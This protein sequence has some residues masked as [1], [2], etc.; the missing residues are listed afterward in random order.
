MALIAF[1][2][3]LEVGLLRRCDEAESL[4]ALMEIMVWTPHGSW[5]SC[6]HLGLRDF[7]EQDA[8]I[9]VRAL[10][11]QRVQEL[12]HALEELGVVCYRLRSLIRE[13]EADRDV[14]SYVLTFESA[15]GDRGTSIHLQRTK[16]DVMPYVIR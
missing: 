3:Q 6:K 13:P 12:N 14:G 9:P 2:L 8:R 11:E 7:F 15:T 5:P 16:S 1:P 4:S 10:P